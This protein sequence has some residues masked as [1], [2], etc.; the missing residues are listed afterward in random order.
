MVAYSLNVL[1]QLFF[2]QDRHQLQRHGTGQRTP[3]KGG[4]VHAGMNAFGDFFRREQRTQRKAA[5]NR[6]GNSYKVRL[7]SV[8]LVGKPFTSAP[9]TTLDLVGDQKRIVLARQLVCGFSKLRAYRTNA[10]LALDKF[11]AN[12][13]DRGVEF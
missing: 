6:F 8:M 12:G 13:A 4:A 9:H 10:A 3:T 11:K 7:D 2:F 5:G 1:E